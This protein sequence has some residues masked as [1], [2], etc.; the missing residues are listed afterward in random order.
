[1]ADNIQQQAKAAASNVPTKAPDGRELTEEEKKQTWSEY[2]K[3]VYNEQYERWMPWIEDFYLRWFTK[4]NKASYATKDTLDKS[5]VTG[6]KQVDNLQD[7]VH[8]LVA[9]Q[10]GQDGM[11]APVGDAFSKEGI[12]R[13]ERQGKDDDGNYVGGP[14]G[15]VVNPI[16]QGGQAVG[17]GVA[18]VGKS[19]GGLFGGGKK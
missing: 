2:G 6:I 12:N 5:K 17:S 11:L 19:V 14:A 4:D 1:M 18:N 7:G 10:V 3:Q 16:A 9:G 15:S 8:G 13:A